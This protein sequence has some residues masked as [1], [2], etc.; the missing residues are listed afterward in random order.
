LGEDQEPAASGDEPGDG[1]VRVIKI[2]NPASPAMKRAAEGEW[3]KR[4]R[5]GQ[6]T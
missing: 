3:W 5:T 4:R 2:K 6:G 1:G